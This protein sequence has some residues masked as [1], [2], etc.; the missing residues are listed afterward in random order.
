MILDVVGIILEYSSSE[1]YGTHF[2]QNA[3]TGGPS[4]RH[5]PRR[6]WSR[7]PRWRPAVPMRRPRVPLCKS[8]LPGGS[9]PLPSPSRSNHPIPPPS[10]PLPPFPSPPPRHGRCRPLHL[11]HARRRRGALLSLALISPIPPLFPCPVVHSSPTKSLALLFPTQQAS[12]ARSR[13]TTGPDSA[14]ASC[15]T[16]AVL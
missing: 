10:L 14:A 11:K 7:R 9:A 12:L 5:Q 16:A 1:T 6:M 13:R 4:P 15:P 2:P 3:K 8:Y